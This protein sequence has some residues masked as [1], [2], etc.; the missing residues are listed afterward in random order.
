MRYK[1]VVVEFLNVNYERFVK[2]YMDF[3][4]KGNYVIRR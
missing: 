1:D 3:L 4:E 2:V